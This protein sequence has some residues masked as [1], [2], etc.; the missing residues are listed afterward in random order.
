MFEKV[1]VVVVPRDRFSSVVDC[2]AALVRHT[3]VPFRLAILDFGYSKRTL[4][5]VRALTGA[6]D[7]DIVRCGRTLP[8][9]A[10]QRYLS[11]IDTPYLAWVDND[12]FVTPGWLTA[13][14]DRASQGARVILPLTLERDGLDADPRGL[15]V[16]NHISHAEL[17]RVNVAGTD[18]VF[19]HKPY[20]RAALAELPPEAHPV[21]FFE[22]H[23]FFAETDVMRQLDYPA[24]VVREHIDFGIQLRQLGIDIW[25]EP[26]SQVHFDNIHLRPSWGDLRFFFYRWSQGLIDQSHELFAQRWGYRFYNEQFLKNWAFRRKVFSVCR[27]LGLP[28]RPADLASRALVKW[29][30]RPIPEELRA[31]PLPRSELALAPREQ[32]AA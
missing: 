32:V 7:T 20:R 28:Q 25:C 30:C 16:R 27:F 21:D 22:L 5:R 29:L 24:M 3:D 6:I 9:L 14:M 19:D 18:Y 31:D 8:V 23:A 10:F 13:L 4:E 26:R 12:T 17:R 11:R 1:T 2:V 15:T